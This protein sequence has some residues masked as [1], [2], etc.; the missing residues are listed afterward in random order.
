MAHSVKI[1]PSTD[2]ENKPIGTDRPH[3]PTP[4]YYPQKLGAVSTLPD[5]VTLHPLLL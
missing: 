3:R 4:K 1:Q 5:E 2:T